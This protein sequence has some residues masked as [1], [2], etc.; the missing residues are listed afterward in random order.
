MYTLISLLP[1]S[2][3]L[4]EWR[5]SEF[6]DQVINPFQCYHESGSLWPD[7]NPSNNTSQP[8]C[9][10]TTYPFKIC[11][12]KG[13]HAGVKNLGIFSNEHWVGNE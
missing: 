10:L 4:P 13:S 2:I 6:S 5:R 9:L 3:T 8:V 12:R 1:R 7:S 11:D